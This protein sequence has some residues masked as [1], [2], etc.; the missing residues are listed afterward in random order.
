VCD[1]ASR[2]TQQHAAAAAAGRVRGAMPKR[3]YLQIVEVCVRAAMS[4]SIA[5]AGTMS[6]GGVRGEGLLKFFETS[7]NTTVPSFHGAR[8]HAHRT[9]PRCTRG[10]RERERGSGGAASGLSGQAIDAL[11][12]GPTATTA[13]PSSTRASTWSRV[14]RTGAYCGEMGG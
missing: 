1:A 12:R 2:T 4:V 8:G 6:I 10:E 5:A 3:V 13:S 7:S 14:A 9:A 11:L